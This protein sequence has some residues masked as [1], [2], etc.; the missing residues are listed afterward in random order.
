MS[1]FQISLELRMM[2]GGGGD[3]NCSYTMCKAPDKSL[4][5]T[6]RHPAFYRPDAFPVVQ[7]TVAKH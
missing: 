7:P 4:A 2:D 6:N 1:L 5:P 3:D